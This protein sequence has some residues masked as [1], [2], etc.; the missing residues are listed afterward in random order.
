MWGVLV[1]ESHLVSVIIYNNWSEKDSCI[2]TCI[3]VQRME[4]TQT[5]LQNLSPVK[6]REHPNMFTVQL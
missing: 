5:V 4:F 1:H 3:V 6:P 2:R